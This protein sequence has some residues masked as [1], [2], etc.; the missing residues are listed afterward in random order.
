[1]H[2][3]ARHRYT[4]LAWGAI[5]LRLSPGANRRL[6]RH[7][8]PS[9]LGRWAVNRTRDP[10]PREAPL[11]GPAAFAVSKGR[12]RLPWRRSGTRATG[13]EYT[14]ELDHPGPWNHGLPPSPG[15][16]QLQ[17]KHHYRYWPA[18]YAREGRRAPSGPRTLLLLL[19]ARISSDAGHLGTCTQVTAAQTY[20]GQPL[21][22]VDTPQLSSGI[23]AFPAH[24][25][26]SCCPDSRP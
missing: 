15:M 24:V 11:T 8:R 5:S 4:G 25:L 23:T 17:R 16:G 12:T 2:G 18:P 20:T 19:V 7:M 22:M 14:Q 1:M 26:A 13:P 21:G 6:D 10:G 3:E 9:D